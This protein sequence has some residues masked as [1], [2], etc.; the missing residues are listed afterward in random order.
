MSIVAN[1]GLLHVYYQTNQSPYTTKRKSCH[2]YNS[3]DQM[4]M[5][6]LP[7]LH[8]I[9]VPNTANYAMGN[10]FLNQLVLVFKHDNE[11]QLTYH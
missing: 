8:N 1:S 7:L 4:C 11:I 5:L 10:E 2:N 6:F 9:Y 3:F